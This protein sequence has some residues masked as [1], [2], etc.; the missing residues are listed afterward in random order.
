MKTLISKTI[1]NGEEYNKVS[2]LCKFPTYLWDTKAETYFSAFDKIKPQLAILD[3]EDL[4]AEF[5]SLLKGF[6]AL[7]IV[8]KTKNFSIHCRDNNLNLQSNEVINHMQVLKGYFANR[9][10]M[11]TENTHDEIK[12]SHQF[13]TNFNTNIVSIEPAADILSYNPKVVPIG[14]EYGDIDVL[15]ISDRTRSKDINSL[16]DSIA[17]SKHNVR[18]IGRAHV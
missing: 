3:A 5:V 14:E 7:R 1:G 4:N 6:P 9:M 17:N 15:I 11:Y 10:I 16:V 18:K 8:L 12:H 13:W 2:Q